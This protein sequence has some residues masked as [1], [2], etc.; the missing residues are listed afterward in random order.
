MTGSL[1]PASGLAFD[2]APNP[3]LAYANA[4]DASQRELV[5]ALD[6]QVYDDAEPLLLK[7]HRFASETFATAPDDDP[8]NTIYD[9]RA[10]TGIVISRIVPT[11][12]AGTY[13]G[14]VGR[15]YGD[16]TLDNADGALDALA[17]TAVDGREV[18]VRA[19][20][21]LRGPNGER[22]FALS[23]MGTVL[24][25]RGAYWTHDGDKLRLGLRDSL[26]DYRQA[27]QESR[28]AGTGGA[29]GPEELEGTTKPL[30]WGRAYLVPATLINAGALI[31][32]I[33]DGRIEA[34]DA[35][36][37]KGAALTAG[38]VRT[39]GYAALLAN[40]PAP[41]T[42]DVATDTG[43]FRLGSI[44][45]GEVTCDVR[46]GTLDTL[47]LSVVGFTDGTLFDD[48][49]GFSETTV[50]PGYV[51][52][53]GSVMI[54]ILMR[55]GRFSFDQIDAESFY[56]IDRIQTAPIGVHF[57]S[58]DE[59]TTA[60]ALEQIAASVGAW[61]GPDRLGNAQAVRLSEPRSQTAVS[62][63]QSDIYALRR[64]PLRYQIPPLGFTVGYRRNWSGAQ[65]ESNIVEST[66][67]QRANDLTSEY[68]S[69]NYEASTRL[70]RNPTAAAVEIESALIAA[71]ADAILEAERLTALYAPGRIL[72]E[73][74][75]PL[76]GRWSL[77]RTIRVASTRYGLTDGRNLVIV[78]MTE[79]HGRNRVTLFLYG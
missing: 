76:F 48:L 73:I 59:S 24:K 25:A 69:A 40:D 30:T 67:E 45:A 10:E 53:A 34:I 15:T 8:A 66:P 7:W 16:L 39:G 78:G 13:G 11:T 42:F 65:S 4:I 12:S 9:G 19:G 61:V 35:I 56:E 63:T 26:Y 21:V 41:G 28:F 32:Q 77:G 17:E 2:I 43:M 38:V 29:E 37:D 58:G 68:R 55:S 49:A 18:V 44:P 1:A 3:V 60:E 51:E 50:G 46:G 14:I 33:H 31:Y 57:E 47:T 71:Q 27:L 52:Q 5:F 36:Y 20:V 6:V 62:I 75:T 79:D 70:I 64:L 74:V 22:G 72:I 23:Q 54:A